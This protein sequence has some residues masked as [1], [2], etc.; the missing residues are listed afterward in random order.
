M[1]L[2]NLNSWLLGFLCNLSVV[3][4][5]SF[6]DKER[7]N[8]LDV[9]RF[10][11]S[12]DTF[13]NLR[14]GD[15][16]CSIVTNQ[17]TLHFLVFAHVLLTG[18]EAES[19]DDFPLAVVELNQIVH[20]LGGIHELEKFDGTGRCAHCQVKD[21]VVLTSEV[22]EHVHILFLAG[23]GQSFRLQVES[24]LVPDLAC[25]TTQILV[26][27]KNPELS[28]EPHWAEQGL[29]VV[30][31]LHQ[32]GL[33]RDGLVVKETLEQHGDLEASAS[34]HELADKLGQVAWDVVRLQHVDGQ[35]N[36]V[37]CLHLWV[38]V[39]NVLGDLKANFFDA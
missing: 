32:E 36:D 22:V 3:V 7:Q 25:K 38:S 5:A 6:W 10:D 28:L 39:K 23:E 21:A 11:V 24:E 17:A 16:I 8:C 15:S 30:E 12:R 29:I 33:S 13:E 37:D 35:A 20:K 4:E 2:D 26:W 27:E 9:F 18:F 31:D 14:N 19:F 34:L 1:S